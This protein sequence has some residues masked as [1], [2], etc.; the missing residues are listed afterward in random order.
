LAL[1]GLAAAT[2]A[3]LGGDGLTPATCAAVE[4]GRDDGVADGR[5]PVAGDILIDCIGDA[6]GRWGLW[7]YMPPAPKLGDD[8]II[9]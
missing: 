1:D 7:L 9:G 2:G 8:I 6:R 5:A 3:G 4:V